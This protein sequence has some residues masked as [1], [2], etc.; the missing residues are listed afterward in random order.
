ML[1]QIAEHLGGQREEAVRKQELDRVRE[2][3]SEMR[4]L[5]GEDSHLATA[6]IDGEYR[7]YAR[8]PSNLDV[9]G[10]EPPV[11]GT[12]QSFLDGLAYLNQRRDLT[13]RSNPEALFWAWI[14]TTAPPGVARNI[15][16]KDTPPEWGIPQVQPEQVR[17]MTYMALAAGYR[18]LSFLGDTDLTR[19]AGE[20]L[21][22]EL[23][24][25][26]AEINLCEP[27]LARNVKRLKPYEVFDP[28]PLTRPTTAN[29]MQRRM[30]Q[31]KEFAGKYGLVATPILLDENRGMLLLI[32]EF[33][34]DP[35]GSRPRWP[36]II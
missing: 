5:E 10:I 6:T 1:W 28:E 16:G 23:T 14:P 27:I 7:L 31:V 30:P 8:S 22:I 19:P 25:L 35:S 15:W 12:S 18:G 33:A 13:V 3:L 20:A 36:T 17:L 24:L 4:G 29:V 34:G 26:N 21:L 2:I 9:I 11:W 32:S